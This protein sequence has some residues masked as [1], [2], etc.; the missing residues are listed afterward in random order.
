MLYRERLS[1]DYIPAEFDAFA[2]MMREYTIDR[3]ERET[4]LKLGD[5]S[6]EPENN[7]ED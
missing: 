3:I 1:I 7:D 2:L 5:F 4:D 6:N